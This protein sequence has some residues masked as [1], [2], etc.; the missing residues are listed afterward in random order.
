MR[1]LRWLIIPA[2]LILGPVVTR[3][4]DLLHSIYF[5]SMFAFSWFCFAAFVGLALSLLLWTRALSVIPFVL[6]AISVVISVVF[7]FIN[8]H[9]YAVVG[10]GNICQS[11]F[12]IVTF[13]ACWLLAKRLPHFWARLARPISM[14]VIIAGLFWFLLSPPQFF[15]PVLFF[16]D[17]TL[18]AARIIFAVFFCSAVLL[19][20]FFCARTAAKQN[21]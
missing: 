2:V 7:S 10:F 21:A 18:S 13:G 16:P 9:T 15:L 11:I 4:S 3:G 6:G 14:S 1:H 5:Y 8:Q 12:T 19:T 17:A 20:I